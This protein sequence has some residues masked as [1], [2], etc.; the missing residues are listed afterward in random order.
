MNCTSILKCAL[1]ACLT[2]SGATQAQ[3][4]YK[5]VD[6]GRVTFSDKPCSTGQ[7]SVVRTDP[8]TKGTLV[9]RGAS[10]VIA[11]QQALFIQ[12]LQ[13]GDYRRA[14]SLAVTEDQRAYVRQ[15]VSRKAFADRQQ[16]AQAVALAQQVARD[17][18]LVEAAQRS[19]AAAEEANRRAARPKTM[20]CTIVGVS[21]TCVEVEPRPRW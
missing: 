1:C 18:A 11:Q 7:Q 14:E 10:P 20:N 9:N 15:G 16:E 8:A 21:G 2:V 5:C 3:E 13:A 12:A 17:Q 6:G 4:A 19:A